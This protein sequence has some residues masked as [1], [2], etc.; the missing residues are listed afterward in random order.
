MPEIASV[1]YEQLCKALRDKS[2]LV[3]DVRRQDEIDQTG[4]IPTACHIPRIPPPAHMT[5]L[6]DH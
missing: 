2:G 5:I 4:T 3:I 6:S 1:D